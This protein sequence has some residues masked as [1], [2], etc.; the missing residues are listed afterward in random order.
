[1]VDIQRTLEARVS[2]LPEAKKVREYESSIKKIQQ[3]QKDLLAK[4]DTIFTQFG[5]N[6]VEYQK[7]LWKISEKVDI[8]KTPSYSALVGKL[9]EKIQTAVPTIKNIIDDL[10]MN[11]R[12][13]TSTKMLTREPGEGKPT[14]WELGKKVEKPVP[15]YIPPTEEKGASQNKGIKKTAS[16]SEDVTQV[17][18]LFA[19][20]DAVVEEVKKGLKI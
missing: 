3:Q 7:V 4:V 16:I 19:E 2:D 9:I 20:I 6:L 11:T 10:W 14:E 12:T 5:V 15:G 18:T 13:M 1:L 8:A 17:F